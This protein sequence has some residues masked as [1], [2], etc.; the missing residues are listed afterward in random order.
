MNKEDQYLVLSLIYML[1]FSVLFLIAYSYEV[2]ELSICKQVAIGH[3]MNY[4]EIK[5][6]CK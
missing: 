2:H 6:L 4:L 3:N 5:E 1:V